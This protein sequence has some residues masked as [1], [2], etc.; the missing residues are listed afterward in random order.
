MEIAPFQESE[1]FDALKLLGELEDINALEI[2]WPKVMVRP[3]PA[4]DAHVSTADPADWDW[5]TDSRVLGRM[6]DLPARTGARA[7]ELLDELRLRLLAEVA[8]AP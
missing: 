6:H 7:L 3:M 8:A 4:W 1:R 5:V 2:L